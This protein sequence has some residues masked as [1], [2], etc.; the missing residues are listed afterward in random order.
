MSLLWPIAR[1]LLGLQCSS[2]AHKY[3]YILSWEWL[4]SFG[5]PHSTAEISK[6]SPSFSNKMI[7]IRNSGYAQKSP[8]GDLTFLGIITVSVKMVILKIHKL[9]LNLHIL[10]CK[11]QCYQ[12]TSR[13]TY[14]D[15]MNMCV[16]FFLFYFLFLHT[17][18]KILTD[19]IMSVTVT[20]RMTV[21]F[22]NE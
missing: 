22:Y 11:L 20:I 17:I 5:R 2:L 8:S 6:L 3:P 10:I 19:L 13:A 15:S 1:K 4:W 16:N 14:I 7:K 18:K 9:P 12:C 21:M